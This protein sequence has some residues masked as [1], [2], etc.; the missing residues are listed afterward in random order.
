M[1]TLNQ[2]NIAN[3]AY[4]LVISGLIW[5]AVCQVLYSDFIRTI[6]VNDTW[7]LFGGIVGIYLIS[8][9]V[10]ATLASTWVMSFTLR[11]VKENLLKNRGHGLSIFTGLLSIAAICV[12]VL[13]IPSLF[14][15]KVLFLPLPVVF[16]TWGWLSAR[17]Y[18][19]KSP[20]SIEKSKRESK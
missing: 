5:F 18:F 2:R 3:T 12:V 10:S 14:N 8:I 7:E 17:I 16:I 11:K 4:N 19:E 6:Q 9:G 1:N 20:A 13:F 15:F